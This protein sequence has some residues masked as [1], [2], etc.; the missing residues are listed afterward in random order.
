[1]LYF[2]NIFIHKY[3]FFFHSVS[4]LHS[5]G[6]VGMWHIN[7]KLQDDFKCWCM[8]KSFMLA[9]C[10]KELAWYFPYRQQHMPFHATREDDHCSLLTATQSLGIHTSWAHPLGLGPMHPQL[11]Q[12]GRPWS[13]ATPSMLGSEHCPAIIEWYIT[14]IPILSSCSLHH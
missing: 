7:D 12:F 5:C 3:C 10:L 6:M 9:W 2:I 4:C 14:H 13:P 8:F 1:M 11:L